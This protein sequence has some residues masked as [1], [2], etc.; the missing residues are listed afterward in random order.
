MRLKRRVKPERYREPE[1]VAAARGR[2][3]E[4]VWKAW[5]FLAWL[6]PLTLVLMVTG[7]D[8][9]GWETLF[10]ILASPILLP[11]AA[12]VCLVPRMILRR[13]GGFRSSTTLVSVAMVVHW[14]SL[15]TFA[16]SHRG[17]GDSGTTDSVLAGLFSSLGE[18]QEALLNAGSAIVAVL[19]W[20]CATVFA[21]LAVSSSPAAPSP[22]ASS[23]ESPVSPAS[24]VSPVPLALLASPAP[25][26][27][28]QG[29]PRAVLV[30]VAAVVAPLVAISAGIVGVAQGQRDLM[31]LAERQMLAWDTAQQRLAPVRGGIAQAGWY[32]DTGGVL[33]RYD[34]YEFV[35]GWQ[36]RPSGS[37][38]EVEARV[39][40]VA[41]DAGWAL[42][43]V[44][45][46]GPEVLSAL[47]AVS[48]DGYELY[49][50]F[51]GSQIWQA[52][53]GDSEV[54]G[55]A[56]DGSAAEG[57]A[58]AGPADGPFTRVTLS[59]LTPREVDRRSGKVDWRHLATTGALG[60]ELD[61]KPLDRGDPVRSFGAGEWPSLP[62][63]QL[64]SFY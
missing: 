50:E 32:S 24:P 37:P 62:Q 14:W 60:K 25:R 17:T 64:S 39:I 33:Q 13:R 53:A 63:Q 19:S 27:L 9:G 29:R 40:E 46:P 55:G 10:V 12:L 59:M 36:V 18:K 23:P 5:P 51:S 52:G 45:D 44:E 28:P 22:A 16:L 35:V 11:V 1:T 2:Q 6:L 42:S 21:V 41:E 15:V 56:A 8:S 61:L 49:V 47:S 31:A 57:S 3:N 34:G 54:E 20:G 58:A 30:T 48:G 38:E 7:S 43:A 26:S 4:I